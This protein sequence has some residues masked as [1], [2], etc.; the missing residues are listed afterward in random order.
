MQTPSSKLFS[1]Q[2]LKSL[3]LLVGLTPVLIHRSKTAVPVIQGAAGFKA[4]NFV[5][6][7]ATFYSV[8]KSLATA[9]VAFRFRLSCPFLEWQCSFCTSSRAG[10]ACLYVLL[11]NSSFTI[12]YMCCCLNTTALQD[13][14]NYNS[15]T[16]LA[17]RFHVTRYLKVE[18]A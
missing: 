6:A 1:V 9:L 3:D 8:P 7:I 10:T 13:S 5:G 4:I 17:V 18:M 16:Y 2:S 14:T 15:S 12:N 11:K